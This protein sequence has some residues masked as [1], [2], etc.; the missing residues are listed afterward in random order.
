MIDHEAQFKALM[1]RGLDGDASA[2]RVLLSDLGGHLRA[3]FGRRLTEAADAEDLVQETLIAIHAKRSTWDPRQPFTSWAYAIARHKMIDHF[4]RQ[5]RRPTHPIEEAGVLFADH[6]VED[7]AVRADLSRCLSQLPAR[8]RRLI[9]DVRVTGL[10]MAEAAG[11]HGYSVAAAKVSVH[12][13]LKALMG[14]YG[15]LEGSSVQP[16][17]DDENG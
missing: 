15:S 2:W 1:R 3:Y 8:Q 17:G 4:R 10:S 9:E 16:G 11:R 13:S 12:R 6:T 14:R 7:G 5:G